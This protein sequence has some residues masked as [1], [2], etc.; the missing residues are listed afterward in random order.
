MYEKRHLPPTY[1][2][3][4]EMSSLLRG[5]AS[6]CLRFAVITLLYR[7]DEIELQIMVYELMH[8]YYITILLHLKLLEI[9]HLFNR[10]H[11]VCAMYS[12][13]SLSMSQDKKC[14]LLY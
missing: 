3:S 1:S 12:V 4:T 10:S 5:T 7:V 9:Y 8:V 14:F 13:I 11:M 6:A 2:I